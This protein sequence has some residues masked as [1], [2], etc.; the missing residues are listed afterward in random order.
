MMGR[1]GVGVCVCEC[2]KKRIIMQWKGLFVWCV[3]CR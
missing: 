2:E 3:Y 1:V